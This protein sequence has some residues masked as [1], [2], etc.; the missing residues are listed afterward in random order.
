M[1]VLKWVGIGIVGVIALLLL[2]VTGLNVIPGSPL[3]TQ[4]DIQPETIAVP[5]DPAA[6]AHGQYLAES[7]GVCVVCHGE[8]LAGRQMVDS[9]V[10]GS[11]HTPNLTAGAGGVGATYSDADWVRS[12]RHGVAPDGHG[13]IFMPTDYYYN[14][15]DADL[16]AIIAYIK[17]LPPVDNTAAET[18]LNP[19]TV[20]LLNAGQFGEV[21][22][23][24]DIVHDAP[25][26]DPDANY[27]AYLLAVGGCTFCHGP[28]WRGGQGP[29]PGAPPAPDITGAGP[30]GERSFDEFAATM[31]T[32][33][34]PNGEQ[35]NPAFMPWAGYSRMT[36]ADLEAIWNH[37]QTIE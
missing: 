26:P 28:D 25:R 1:G 19:V 16:G 3:D 5:T 13:L 33:I 9:P 34:M 2:V 31:R 4:F 29:E 36:D 14:L 20:A 18:R 8:N 35:I 37:L 6:V 27:G 32:G 23:A 10:L 12:L 17:T 24:R 15:S 21:V 7:I 11:I 30:W 22:R